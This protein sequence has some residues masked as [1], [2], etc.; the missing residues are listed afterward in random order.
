MTMMVRFRPRALQAALAFMAA[1]PLPLALPAVSAQ[2]QSASQP[3]ESPEARLKRIEAELRAVQRKVFPDG[4]GKTFTPEI[5]AGTAAQ[6]APTGNPAVADLLSRMD[7]VEAQIKSLTAQAEEGQNRL[8]KLEARITALEPPAP[9]TPDATAPVP[10]PAASVPVTT[11]T[12]KP[13]AKPAAA[14][15]AA[16][17]KVEPSAARLAAVQAIEKPVSDDKGEDLYS[18]GYRLWEARFYPESQQ[19]LTTFVQ[20]YPKH[21][22][23]SYARNLLGRAY[24][25]DNKPGTAAQ[26]F[27]QNYLND[28][29]GDRA[30]D[31]LLYLGVAMTRLKETKRACTAFAEFKST[32]PGEAAGRLKAQY[33]AA[34]KTVACN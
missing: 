15:S 5:T 3:Q 6:A 19:A 9:V 28:K 20:Q 26:W 16:S 17:A 25:D 22:R 23:L 2:A 12:P 13:A 33:D 11:P 29:Q 31:S 8:N 32:Y 30:A 34:S 14:A 1:G 21:K 10:A 18:Y 27:V 24:L 4:A 7:A